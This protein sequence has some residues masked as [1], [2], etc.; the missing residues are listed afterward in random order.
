[1]KKFQMSGLDSRIHKR[2]TVVNIFPQFLVFLLITQSS[3]LRKSYIDKRWTMRYKERKE[4]YFGKSR[5][6]SKKDSMDLDNPN[7][8][9]GSGS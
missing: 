7:G 5:N 4:N 1:M 3:V 2:K 8:R 9:S 6:K